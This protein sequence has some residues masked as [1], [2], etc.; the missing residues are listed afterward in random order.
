MHWRL[1]PP[2]STHST[3][4]LLNSPLEA[5]RCLE[6]AGYVKL[7]FYQEIMANQ[8]SWFLS[9]HCNK[10]LV[11]LL[12]PFKILFN[13]MY[14]AGKRACRY[15]ALHTI[16]DSDSWNEWRWLWPSLVWRL[17]VAMNNACEIY[18]MFNSYTFSNLN[19]CWSTLLHSTIGES[20][21]IENVTN[22]G[23]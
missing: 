3:L 9:L 15:W 21:D 22:S 13:P 16:Q 1:A 18:K 6:L 17:I 19:Q 8:N 12:I 4:R 20:L 14:L 2:T 7:S 5:T 11:L 10:R 23:R